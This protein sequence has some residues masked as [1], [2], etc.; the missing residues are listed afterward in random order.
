MWR[1]VELVKFSLADHE[2]SQLVKKKGARL[3]CKHKDS[4]N[5][6]KL[7]LLGAGLEAGPTNGTCKERPLCSADTGGEVQRGRAHLHSFV[8][9]EET[10]CSQT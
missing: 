9:L 1:Q 6:L 5:Q 7:L 10:K 3:L 2:G 4:T 8:I